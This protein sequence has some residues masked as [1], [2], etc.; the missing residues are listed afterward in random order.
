MLKDLKSH[1]KRGF[2]RAKYYEGVRYIGL[3]CLVAGAAG[4]F[5]GS[6]KDINIL[7]LNHN[8]LCCIGYAIVGCGIWVYGLFDGEKK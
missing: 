3:G 2:N 4:I 5:V 1:F 7:G 8:Y 6:Y